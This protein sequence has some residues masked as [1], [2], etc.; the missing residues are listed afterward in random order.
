MNKGRWA[1]SDLQTGT[2]QTPNPPHAPQGKV[3]PCKAAIKASKLSP[4]PDLQDIAVPQRE[5]EG[6][7]LLH[8]AAILPR[9]LQANGHVLALVGTSV[10]SLAWHQRLLLE[11]AIPWARRSQRHIS[12]WLRGKSLTPTV[13]SDSRPAFQVQ[14]APV[15]PQGSL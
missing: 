11:Q 8:H 7:V 2:P 1:T 3:L 15:G 6:W 9:G 13:R 14:G 12:P 5:G 10:H 4:S